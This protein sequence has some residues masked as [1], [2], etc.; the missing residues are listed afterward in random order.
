MNYRSIVHTLGWVLIFEA[1]LMLF[2]LI[3]SIIYKESSGDAFIL[4]LLICLLFGGIL[5]LIPSKRNTM[6]AKEGFVT[7]ALSWITMS[8][9]GAL[10][11]VFSGTTQSY[12]D[13]L[14]EI[15]SGFTTTGASILTD[16]D[17]VP[18]SIILWRSFSHF[19]GG[20]GVL[21]FLVALLPLFGGNNLHLFRAE[22][23][24]PSV[25]KLV[26]KMRQTAIILY[27]IYISLTGLQIIFL[28]F[29]GMNFFDA[30]TISFG[31]AGTGGFSIV[32]SG[33]A[34]YSPYVQNVVTVF[35]IIFGIDFSLYYLILIGN[36]RLAFSS[37]ELK[38]Y[39]GII[40]TSI[41]IITLNIRDIYPDIMEAIRLSAFHVGSIIT[42]TG[43]CAADFNMW[44]Q[45]S[46]TILVLLMFIGACAGSTGGG[47]K[48][49]RI[50]ILLKSIAK[51]IKIA[52][53]PRSTHKI[54]MNKRLVEHE[55][56]RSVN[57]FIMSYLMIF[58]LS[59]LLIS[60]DNKDFTTSFTS[61]LATLNNIGPGLCEV[62][63]ISNFSGFS[64]FSKIILTLDM[65]IGRLEIF[66][67]LVLFSP[68]TWKK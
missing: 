66:P 21:V 43:Y 30:I 63:P 18:K 41:I 28:L 4:C 29:G 37:S 39:L 45:L 51:E 20:M 22:A 1:F 17:S 55:T 68:Y 8:I 53:H 52:S 36:F 50:I 47:I 19:I 59:L 25:N 61:V 2:P 13:A 54:T 42:T 5:L 46:K 49:S 23:P 67:V 7:V 3:C 48:V 38:A 15:T 65:L 58:A 32:N 14:F 62:G 31:T 56:I 10:P 16:L 35:M 33:F 44:P 9:F 24:G 6:Y 64:D 27:S 12:I 11:F 34:D 60:I 57:V 26:P 40:I